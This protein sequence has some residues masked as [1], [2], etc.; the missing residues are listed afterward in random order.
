MGWDIMVLPTGSRRL[1]EQRLAAVDSVLGDRGNVIEVL[2][3][4]LPAIN[5]NDDGSF[6]ELQEG[7]CYVEFILGSDDPITHMALEV[8]ALSVSVESGLKALC[9]V[10]G[11][12]LYDVASGEYIQFDEGS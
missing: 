6:G 7:D 2:R 9:L 3:Q 5:F 8:H 10:T 1:G 4:H 11:W 12:E